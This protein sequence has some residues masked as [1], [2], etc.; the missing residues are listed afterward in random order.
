V[1]RTF[2]APRF[3]TAY[4]QAIEPLRLP[5]ELTAGSAAQLSVVDRLARG[6]AIVGCFVGSPA[7]LGVKVRPTGRPIRVTVHFSI[8]NRSLDW[9]EERV[10]EELGPRDATTPR[11]FVVRSQGKTRGAV[12]LIRQAV[13]VG[14]GTGGV[15]T[16][17]LQPDELSEQGL[18]VLEV[19][20][21]DHDLPEWAVA[22]P[23]GTVGVRVDRI[24][25]GE[26]VKAQPDRGRV[27]T[28][29]LPVN[30]DGRVRTLRCG[31]FVANPVDDPGPRS[32]VVRA[33]LVSRPVPVIADKTT[34]VARPTE[35][36]R[37]KSRGAGQQVR[38]AARWVVPIAALP[39][40]KRASRRLALLDRRLRTG[41]RPSPVSG[42]LSGRPQQIANVAT[43]AH[44]PL[45]DLMAD[46]VQRNL[47]AVELV[48]LEGGTVPGVTVRAR[49]D[50]GL[51]IV[52]DGPL[53]GPV[54]VRLS[55]DENAF[56]GVPDIRGRAVRW[57]L[58]TF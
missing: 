22:A 6:N 26:V 7:M 20:S 14:A 52:V 24:E 46:L 1:T 18:F 27:S 11:L 33:S 19:I 23:Q 45:A 35:Q 54:L 32:W 34:P 41:A 57:E 53:P 30:G 15:V 3:Q 36:P 12:L 5:G 29:H 37:R 9:W 17:D 2:T 38:R 42:Q 4:D 8:D 51:E 31:Y 50:A 58:V 13:D 40:A 39:A 44:D 55:I 49:P 25:F 16:F 28:G 47:V 43:P 21:A 56:A 10:P 48:A